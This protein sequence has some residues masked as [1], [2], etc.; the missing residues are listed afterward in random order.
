MRQTRRLGLAALTTGVVLAVGCHL[1]AGLDGLE[2]R[3]GA[4]GGVAAGGSGGQAAAGGEGGGGEEGGAAGAG[5]A[6]ACSEPGDCPGKDTTCRKRACK[7]GI[8]SLTDELVGTKCED[9]GSCDGA[10]T[11]ASGKHLWSKGFLPG[12]VWTLADDGAGS[13][14]L[15]GGLQGTVDFGGGPLTSAGSADLYAQVV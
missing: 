13:A 1:V 5:G 10:G 12:E 9:G 15:T 7:K 11:C 4:G 2:F 6:T 8:C 3:K 14:L